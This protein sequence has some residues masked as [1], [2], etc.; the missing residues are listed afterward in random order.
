MRNWI[1]LGGTAA[2]PEVMV[3]DSPVSKL[4]ESGKIGHKIMRDGILWVYPCRHCGQHSEIHD[5]ESKC[6]DG[7]NYY[8]NK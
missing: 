1:A 6:L 8:S 5:R 4:I 7:K 3:T 2:S